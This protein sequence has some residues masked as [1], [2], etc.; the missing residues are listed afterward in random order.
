MIT[1]RNVKLY[2]ATYAVG[3]KIKIN[4]KEQSESLPLKL[5]CLLFT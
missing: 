1:D 2:T 5:M 4:K 3:V